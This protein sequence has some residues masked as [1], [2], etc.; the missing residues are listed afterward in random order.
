VDTLDV[1]SHLVERLEGF[2]GP[3][4]DHVGGVEIDG[5]IVALD[6]ADESEEGLGGFLAGLQMK[7]LAIAS[8]VAAD[9]LSERHGQ[10]GC[11]PGWRGPRE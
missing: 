8:A 9:F 11:I 5:E 1:C 7:S 10:W 6:V 3:V 2:A 4:E